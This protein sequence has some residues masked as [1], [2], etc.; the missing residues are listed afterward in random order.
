MNPQKI[1]SLVVALMLLIGGTGI[2]VQSNNPAFTL[3]SENNLQTLVVQEFDETLKTPKPSQQED[4]P[5][6]TEGSIEK[7][8]L[9]QLAVSVLQNWEEGIGDAITDGSA[10]YNTTDVF[11][12]LASALRT[13]N[14]WGGLPE[15]VPLIH[16]TRPGQQIDVDYGIQVETLEIL[17]AADTLEL[18]EK[19]AMPSTVTLASFSITSTEMLH[20]M[21]QL[22]LLLEK[23]EDLPTHLYIEPAKS[24]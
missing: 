4:L 11:G 12:L 21:A 10:L 20:A 13:Y 22:Y 2:W 1:P 17:E 6:V 8:A 23:G 18:T 9:H 7:P 14:Q 16:L 5:W 24:L 15:T 19:T 3:P